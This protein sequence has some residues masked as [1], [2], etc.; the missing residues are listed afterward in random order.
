MENNKYRL[1]GVINLLDAQTDFV[2]PVFENE[3]VYFTQAKTNPLKIDAFDFLL[4][5]EMIKRIKSIHQ[6]DI[7]SMP[8]KKVDFV[9]GDD[10]LY[11]FQM[12][13]NEL[14]LGNFNEFK[15]YFYSKKMNIND[16]IYV[17]DSI[18]EIV[19]CLRRR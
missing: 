6:Y 16:R 11:G 1:V 2:I 19:N 9:E 13:N 15:K 14:F 7:L 3:G 18:D 4:N 8:N 12:N 5:S 17:Q 10:V